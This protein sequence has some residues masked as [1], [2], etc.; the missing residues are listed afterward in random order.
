MRISS[1]I[2]GDPLK[3]ENLEFEKLTKFKALAIFSADVLSSVTY[4]TE[5]ILLALGAIAA[6]SFS[7]SIAGIIV[8]LLIVISISYWQTISAYSTEGDA[9]TVA[10][11]NLGE[12]LGLISASALLIDYV[13]TVAVS[14]SAGIHVIVSAFPYLSNYNVS[15]CLI[16]LL[17]ITISNLRGSKELAAVLSRPTYCFIG[18]IFL[19]IL[20][21][22]FM[23]TPYL[24]I[25]MIPY[26]TSNALVFV[27]TLRA[28]ASGCC[29][30]T[31]I[32]SIA[33]GVASFKYPQYKNAQI[34]LAAMV[35]ILSILFLGITFLANKYAIIPNNEEAVIS[36]IARY[37]FGAG[38]M[39]YCVQI[40]CATIL[41]TA[42]SA[43]FS[44]FPGLAYTLA[45]RKYIPTRFAN[46]G[47]R[48]AFSNGIIVLSIMAMLIIIM[49]KGDSHAL[50]PLYSLG[51]FISYTL[52]QA[53]MVKY[54]AVNRGENW[55]IKVA[56]NAIGAILTF[57]TLLIIME[58]KFLNGAWIVAI[59]VPILF[60]LFKKINR[61]YEATN[62]EL[63]L[64]R[65]RLGNLIQPLKNTK[66]KVVIP[67]SRIHKGTLSALRFA[68]SLSEDV[69]AV[70]INV[71]EREV[72]R[73]KLT[74]KAMNFSMPLAI[75]KSPY[76]SLVNPFLDF[77]HEQDERESERGK[78]I[79]V[80]PSF[81]PGKFWQN[82]LHNQTA[83]I[84]KTAL[85]YKKRKS[86][87]TRII[88]EIPYQM[89]IQE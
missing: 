44:G 16:A 48:L 10:H 68:A 28:F 82:I 51:V 37:V 76:R 22:F 60:C 35:V 40:I 39:Y 57:L 33:S 46:L 66:P 75:L 89:K 20:C 69:T 38:F 26:N 71:D 88:V 73:L 62:V 2:F 24:E 11:Q 36:Q 79:V 45:K 53:G 70:V 42:A 17:F 6:Y 59:L 77:L 87:Q 67:I 84:L 86:E 19:M 12:F 64:K 29:A 25:P 34:T 31:G 9:F 58:S 5:E 4:A 32:E 15:L 47:D 13:L 3:T 56:V 55:P 49:F 8:G 80:M 74:W 65:G 50:I 54:W 83:T 30:L 23:E 63:D 61:R 72:N 21:G 85:L 7:L 27:I 1:F 18:I 14:L 81:V 78:T 43:S 52:S 41:L